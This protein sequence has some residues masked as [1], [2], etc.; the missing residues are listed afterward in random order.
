M[1]SDRRYRVA[2]SVMPIEKRFAKAMSQSAPNELLP[3]EFGARRIELLN[4]QAPVAAHAIFF[5]PPS[6]DFNAI[7]WRCQ[8]QRFGSGP[9]LNMHFHRAGALN[10]EDGIAVWGGFDRL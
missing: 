6:I 7:P 9:N 3:R 5:I 4:S 1:S 8:I 2:H 10:A